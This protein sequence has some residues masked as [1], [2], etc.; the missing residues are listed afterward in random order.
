MMVE[1]GRFMWLDSEWS[2]ITQ[3]TD[4]SVDDRDPL[5][6]MMADNVAFRHGIWQASNLC[7]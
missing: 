3:L 4:N 6:V 7:N 2:G 5:L 1:I